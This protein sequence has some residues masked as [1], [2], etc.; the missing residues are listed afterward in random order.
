MLHHLP[1]KLYILSVFRHI[2]PICYTICDTSSIYSVC[3]VTYA[4][5]CYTICHT[6]SIY[7]VCSVTYTPS[8]TPSVI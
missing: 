6:S 2:H 8:V 7:S 1:Y 5:I 3:S 4:P